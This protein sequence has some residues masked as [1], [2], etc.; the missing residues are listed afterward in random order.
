M[1]GKIYKVSPSITKEEILA[2]CEFSDIPDYGE[3]MT[4]K[5]FIEAVEDYSIVDY[6]GTGD[7]I[8]YGSVVDFTS[9][10][11]HNRTV[12]FRD[13]FFIPFDVLYSI[14]GDDMKIIW[15]NK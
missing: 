14:F 3:I 8:L 5:S 12:Y 13:R 9:T 15:F 2:V 10:W 6:D 1:N 11:I 7:L 4:Y